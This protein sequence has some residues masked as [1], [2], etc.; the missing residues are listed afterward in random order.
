MLSGKYTTISRVLE[1]IIRDTGFTNEINFSDAIEWAYRA[2][3]FIGAPQIYIQKVTDG[4]V[5]LG[6]PEPLVVS[7]YRAE[8][9][10]DMQSIIQIREYCNRQSMTTT[11]Y[12][13][14]MSENLKEIGGMS[15][16]Q[17]TI[18]D[19]YI[20][21]NFKDGQLEVAY[22]AFPTDSE[23]YPAIP[24]DERYLKAIESY[25]IERI[26]RKLWL[27]DK[28]SDAKYKALEQ[29]WLFYVRSAKSRAQMPSIDDMERLKNQVLRLITHTDRHRTQFVQL[30]DEEQIRIRLDRLGRAL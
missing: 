23:G 19:N 7:N 21:T 24:D 13:F 20:F 1:N 25:I 5:E 16:L 12:N 11:S 30:G 14:A 4:N 18:N 26:A 8:L 3:Q 2:M 28:I 9:P 17:Y 10:C 29:D 6:H 22:W 27:Q 15:T